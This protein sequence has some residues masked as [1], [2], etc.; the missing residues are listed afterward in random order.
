M[1]EIFVS[2]CCI[3]YNHGSFIKECLDGFLNQKTNFKYEVLIHDDAS[4]DDTSAILQSYAKIY[5]DIIKPIIQHENKFSKGV[6]G[7]HSKF[8]YPRARGKYI[9]LCEGD[10]YWTDPYKLQ[11]QVDFMEAHPDY[12]L[13][14]SDVDGLY[15]D[16][17]EISYSENTKSKANN[18]TRQVSSMDIITNSFFVRTPT[19]LYRKEHI[20]EYNES[21]FVTKYNKYLMM[22]DRQL[23][24]FLAHRGKFHYLSESTAVYRIRGGSASHQVDLKKS[25]RFKLSMRE[26][27]MVFFEVYPGEFD[28][29]YI[30][31]TIKS[32]YANLI[33]Y[34]SFD[35]SYK[36]FID[37]NSKKMAKVERFRNNRL[38]RNVLKILNQ[39][40]FK[41][42]RKY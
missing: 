26:L 28:E 37:T 22:G 6:R 29:R 12:S 36:P 15:D 5:P 14:C 7:F 42:K 41:I 16:T 21:V 2:I 31:K 4:C 13:S 24:M 32:Y 10:D 19:T 27:K 11:K 35:P 18:S 9:A 3:T 23:W 38:Y 33:R 34:I 8:N 25:L 40:K 20:D 17:G 1:D 39:L 30:S